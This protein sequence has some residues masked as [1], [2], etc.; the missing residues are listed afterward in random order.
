MTQ[1][2]ILNESTMTQRELLRKEVL[3]STKMIKL[4]N[5]KSIYDADKGKA[6]VVTKINN[7]FNVLILFEMFT[8]ASV[9]ST[10]SWIKLCF[11]L[12]YSTLKKLES[13]N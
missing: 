12:Y 11:L 8:K 1:A 2:E 10:S 9:S 7:F 13:Q 3:S 4:I 6:Q 5:R